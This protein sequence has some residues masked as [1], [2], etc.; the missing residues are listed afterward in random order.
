MKVFKKKKKQLDKHSPLPNKMIQSRHWLSI[1]QVLRQ[2]PLLSSDGPG[3]LL[4]K[5]LVLS[6]LDEQRLVEKVLDVLVVVE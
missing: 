5:R 4:G 6:E 3:K 1:F 2:S